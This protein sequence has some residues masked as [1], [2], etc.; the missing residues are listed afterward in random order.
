MGNTTP[1]GPSRPSIP[2]KREPS[3][4]T[5]ST[6]ITATCLPKRVVIGEDDTSSA[7]TDDL[8]TTYTY[9][10][11]SDGN[12]QR[13]G[14]DDHRSGRARSLPT[15]T[16]P[17]VRKPRSPTTAVGIWKHLWNTN[18]TALPAKCWPRRMN[19]GRRTEYVF[20][21]LN[22]PDP[23]DPPCGR[24]DRHDDRQQRRQRLRD[25]RNLD[26]RRFANLR[27]R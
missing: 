1:P 26:H 24:H 16:T 23:H 13:S 12:R 5:R 27:S 10:D 21:S 19:W 20:D 14:R 4:N 11:A 22:R 2:T 25:D 8:V 9:T 6:P 7:E 3:P 17:A 15:S 18:T